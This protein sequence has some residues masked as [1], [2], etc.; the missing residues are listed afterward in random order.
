MHTHAV[1]SPLVQDVFDNDDEY[2]TVPDLEVSLTQKM[3]G[4][5]ELF[6]VCN[7][8]KPVFK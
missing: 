2:M 7:R 6:R 3:E 5:D 1:Q 4:K 8:Q